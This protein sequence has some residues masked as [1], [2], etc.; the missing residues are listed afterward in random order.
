MP[1]AMRH[2]KCVNVTMA[3]VQRQSL[4]CYGCAICRSNLRH[5]KVRSGLQK[6]SGLH[7]TSNIVLVKSEAKI[8]SHFTP[9]TLAMAALEYSFFNRLFIVGVQ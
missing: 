8:N 7:Q 9:L 5:I 4:Q 3:T 1:C 6:T 2:M